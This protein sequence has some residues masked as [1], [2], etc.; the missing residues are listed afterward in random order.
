MVREVSFEELVE[1]SKGKRGKKKGGGWVLQ[2]DSIPLAKVWRLMVQKHIWED[3][4]SSGE[5]RYRQM[6]EVWRKW[7]VNR[8]GSAYY[9]EAWWEFILGVRCTVVSN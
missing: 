4:G 5:L 3:C 9:E 2:S 1:V 7:R 6:V 8:K